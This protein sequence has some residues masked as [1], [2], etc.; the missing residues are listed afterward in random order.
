MAVLLADGVSDGLEESDGVMVVDAD[1]DG[2]EV[3]VDE[4]VAVS[5]TE[6]LGVLVAVA[7]TVEVGDIEVTTV[8]VEEGVA[9]EVEGKHQKILWIPTSSSSLS[10]SLFFIFYIFIKRVKNIFNPLSAMQSLILHRGS[11]G[12]CGFKQLRFQ[13]ICLGIFLFLLEFLW[14]S[15][16]AIWHHLPL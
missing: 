2:E 16:R 11:K 15:R 4:G 12:Q 10:L 9:V 8:A 14:M 5:V 1:V 13:S 7:E 3:T 6:P